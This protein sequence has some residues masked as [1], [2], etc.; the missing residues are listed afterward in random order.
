[1][2]HWRLLTTQP[3]TGAENMALDEALMEFARDTGEW[4]LRVYGWSTPTISLGRNQSARGR[5]D[6]VEIA[7][8]TLGMV[9]RPTGGRAILHHREVTYSVTAPVAAAGDLRES[10]E[11]INAVLVHGLRALGVSAEIAAPAARATAPGVAPCFDEPAQ[12]ELT[13]NGRKLAGS[14]QWR[15]EEALL[16]HGSILLEDDQSALSELTLGAS[17]AIPKPAT[18]VESMGRS[19]ALEE[20]ARVLADAVRRIEDPDAEVLIPDE[21]LRARAKALVVRYLDDA[22]TWR[23]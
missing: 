4:V 11:R 15:T 13:V 5:Y 6:V 2:P 1:M 17:R 19:P 18:L 3:A 14:A 20:V 12:G 10:Y 22:W 8:R 23:R 21:I 16:Q 7:R 9:R